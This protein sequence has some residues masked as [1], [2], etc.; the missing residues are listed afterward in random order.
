[1]SEKSKAEILPGLVKL[2]TALAI[3]LPLIGGYNEY[4]Q[5]V[6][7]DLDQNYRDVLENLSSDSRET[8]LAAATSLGTFIRKG[9][10]YENE[11]IDI[12]VNKASI[13]LD[14]SVLNAMRGSLEKTDKKEYKKIVEKL[15][16]LERNVF[17][18]DYVL[19]KLINDSKNAFEESEDRYLMQR[20]LYSR[21]KLD[22]DKM[23]LYK[24]EEEAGRKWN[25]YNNYENELILLKNHSEV[26]SGLI[27]TFLRVTRQYP[28]K[29]LEFFR[30][31]MNY[32]SIIELNLSDA[33][34][35]RSAFSSSNLLDTKF[36]GSTIINTVFTYSDISKSSF[37]NCSIEETLFDRAILKDTD[38]TG[39]KFND[40]FF[41]GSDLTGANFSSVHG[42]N[43]FYF[44]EAKGVDKATFDEEFKQDLVSKLVELTR[45]DFLDYLYNE[46]TLND[47]RRSELLTTLQALDVI[48]Q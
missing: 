16:T 40:V 5:S 48:E 11:S 14:F 29:N 15:L 30:N 33:I 32:V 13:E 10:K 7:Q 24:L 27:A 3:L 42:L 12:L 41:T 1:M 8:R 47:G 46:S 37:I 36:D 39:S 20:E 21:D 22:I 18:Q 31:S 44:Y 19:N 25:T 6:R 4:R 9:G 26:L 2:I 43:E 23:I 45:E 28:I 34:I 35:N 17:E 38:F